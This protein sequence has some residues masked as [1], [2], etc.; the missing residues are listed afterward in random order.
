MGSASIK[1]NDQQK[2]KEQVENK[3]YQAIVDAILNHQ[4]TSGTRLV[5]APLCQAFGVTRGV[6]RRVFIKLAHDKVIEIQPNRGAVVPQYS[7][8]ETEE[9]FDARLILELA[10][11]KKLAQK[12]DAV[13]LTVLKNIV[14]EERALLANGNWKE[15]INLSGKFHIKLSELNPNT[16]V[17]GYLQTLIARTSLLIGMYSKPQHNSCSIDEHVEIIN[18]IE[19]GD[20]EKATALMQHHLEDY[21][22]TFLKEKENKE[23]VD[24]YQLFNHA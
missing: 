17:T 14:K 9:V 4:L 2:D 6:L 21:S 19:K 10:N 20:V 11:V 5:E 1:N 7:A 16:I 22:Q 23:E 13:D 8:K 3:I 15:W 24:L 12:K 18:A